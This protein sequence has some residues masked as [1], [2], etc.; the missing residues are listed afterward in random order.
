MIGIIVESPSKCK[1]IENYLGENYKCI[2]SYGH[3]RMIKSLDDI[4]HLNN[5]KVTY[6]KIP[7][8]VKQIKAIKKF[9]AS[10]DEILLASD[11][12]REGEAIAW[13]IC[14][15][16]KLP[17]K[18]TKRLIFNEITQKSLQNAVKNPTIINMDKVYSQMSRQ[19]IDLIVGFKISP[20]L[21]KTYKK[22]RLSAGR[23]QT[24]ALYIVYENYI[25]NKN[26]SKNTVYKVRGFFTKNNYEMLLDNEFTTYES[27]Y[28]FINDSKT[29]QHIFKKQQSSNVYNKCPEPLTTSVLLQKS[30]FSPKVT[31]KLA[32]DLYE[33]GYITY[34]RTDSKFYSKDFIVKVKG[35][36][37]NKFGKN[38]IKQD[39]NDISSLNVKA[40]ESIRPTNLN[41]T[42]DSLNNMDS[43][44]QQLYK[45]IYNITIKSCMANSEYLAN[46]INITAPDNHQYKLISKKCIFKGWES[47]DNIE[48][49]DNIYNYLDALQNN[50]LI[51]YNKI[52]CYETLQEHPLHL[53]ESRLVNLLE[54][55]GIG[56][57]STFST[58]VNKIQDRQYVIKKNIDGYKYKL[59]EISLVNNEITEEKNEKIMGIE[60]NKLV[61]QP[62]GI[63]VIEYLMNYFQKLFN[64]TYTS[65]MELLLEKIMVKE[66]SMIDVCSN[67]YKFIDDLIIEY[68]NNND[69][70][71]EY[72]IDDEHT[73]IIGKYGPVIKCKSGEFKKVK[74]DL[75]MDKLKRNEYTLDEIVV[76]K[77]NDYILGTYQD[78]PVYLLNGRYG[79]YLKWNGDNYSIKTDINNINDA[80]KYLNVLN[81]KLTKYAELKEGEKGYYVMFKK[82]GM[83][84]P[85]FFDM[86]RY[87]KELNKR[88]TKNIIKWV[89][90]TYKIKL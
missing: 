62:L 32:Q 78:S 71:N 79:K 38:Y 42:F 60:K 2:A 31:M 57:P 43:K 10:M 35:L 50:S 76:E 41:I 44:H 58:L 27:A 13:H 46:K 77:N 21:W 19:I 49:N 68:N 85:K 8:K 88:E 11:D 1:I 66:I 4:D 54:K 5:F 59:N 61:I 48:N 33:N 16:F 3:L 84:R 53:S 75:D 34:M 40:H 28:K 22:R 39:L 30:T 70:I 81:I 55:K 24:P 18:T 20:L 29:F 51:S 6:H 12:D 26:L 82:P 17:V 80:I 86:S 83:K 7:E 69:S 36:I 89:E 63:M 64:Y 9:I 47:V 72:K 14:K 67:S 37:T 56:R 90:E 23:C 65:E 87:K 52:N 45:L 73:F 25:K 15:L 74:T